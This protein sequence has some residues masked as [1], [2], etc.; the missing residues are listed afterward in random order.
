MEIK[1]KVVGDIPANRLVILTRP[2]ENLDMIHI[3]LS[4]ELNSPEF[5]STRDLKDGEV[6]S[7]SLTIK[8]IWE[9]EVGENIEAGVPV[10]SGK[11]GKIVRDI[12]GNK[13]N[14]AWVGYTVE[15]GE[16]GDIVKMVRRD[17][18]SLPWG[19]DVNKNL[20]GDK[21]EG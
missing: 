12:R 13:E 9:V 15:S 4:D 17:T 19:I 10:V 2:K 21:E 16:E 5:V 6:V 3:K 20:V 18:I 8:K 11:G 14:P 1:A 7:I